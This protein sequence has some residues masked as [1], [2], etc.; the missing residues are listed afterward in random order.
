MSTAA[1]DHRLA[2]W[3]GLRFTLSS[4]RKGFLTLVSLISLFGMVLGVAALVLVLSVMNGLHA[5]LR[6]RL[7]VLVPPLRVLPQQGLLADPAALEQRLAQIAP[8]MTASPYLESMAL[9]ASK[10]GL[11]GAKLLGVLPEREPALL[12]HL[13]QADLLL[14]P[15]EFSVVL[16][17][18]LARRLNLRPGDTVSL[19][20]PQLTI[21]PVGA[22]PRS[23]EFRVV[24]LLST[25]SQADNE[26]AIVHRD[27][28]RRLRRTGDAVDGLRLALPIGQEGHWQPRLQAALGEDWRVADWRSLQGPLFDAVQMEKRMI[29]LLLFVVVIVAAF[30]VV[31]V[32]TISVA[33]KASAIAILRTLGASAATVQ[34]A[35][36]IQGLSLAGVGI[37]AGVLLGLLL[38]WQL[39]TLMQGLQNLQGEAAHR[40]PA[41][42]LPVLLQWRDV[43]WVVAG[44]GLL[45]LLAAWLPARQAARVDP[46]VALR[47]L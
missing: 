47:A 34:R 19:L 32:V 38:G 20:L 5:E 16:G 37:L 31:S 21:T 15:D 4:R 40:L 24:A 39:E 26:Y 8:G 18:G 35:F 6:D 36:L 22:F 17:Y 9:L 10:E 45:S 25:G 42:R 33:Q 27:N 12:H 7:L 29:A 13:P 44:A 3:L 46:A 23:R 41:I 1:A 28:A 43:L 2:A 11:Q 14:Q 30:N